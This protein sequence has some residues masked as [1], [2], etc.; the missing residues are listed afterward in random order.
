MNYI[1]THQKPPL[2]SPTVSGAICTFNSQYAGLPL[3]SHEVDITAI[4]SGSGIPSPDNVRPISG[5]S[6]INISQSG[7]DTSTP[8]VHTITI[9]STVYGGEYDAR[10]GLFTVTHILFT[11]TNVD[12]VGTQGGRYFFR[13][14]IPASSYSISM[15]PT[16]LD[17]Y[18]SETYYPALDHSALGTFF[19]TSAG[20]SL[21]LT[22][23]DQ[24][25][26]TVAKMNTYLADNPAVCLIPLAESLRQTIQLP[27]CQID[28]LLGE[29]NIWA[30][31]G[32][33][34]LQYP[35]FG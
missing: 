23:T 22:P 9:G 26:D 12:S 14:G 5:Y 17:N 1:T 34:T 27:P 3:K 4:Q 24:T 8:T 10:T 21:H 13:K 33:T 29:N 19:V 15:T 32:D 28:T 2:S 11:V 7:A 6:A 31:T 16:N 25:L 20:A 35:K 30:D 18:M